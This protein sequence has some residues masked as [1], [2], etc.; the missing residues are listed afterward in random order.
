MRK[1]KFKDLGKASRIVKKLNLR[2]DNLDTENAEA[3]GA[4]LF[5]KLIE[6]YSYAENEIAE[7]MAELKD[8]TAEEYKEQELDEIFNDFEELKKDPGL[9]NFFKALKTM[10]KEQ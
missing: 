6:N 4:S 2:A 5:L 1:L 9:A 3:L 7:F 10:T 8:V